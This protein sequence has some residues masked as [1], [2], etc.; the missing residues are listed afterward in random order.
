MTECYKKYREYKRQAG[1]HRKKWL[2][3]LA[4]DR[5]R[6]EFISNKKKK[7]RQLATAKHI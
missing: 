3:E 6:E 2:T 4:E 1:Q 7:G 5:A